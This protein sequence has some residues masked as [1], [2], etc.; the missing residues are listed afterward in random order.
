MACDNVILL[1]RSANQ[2]AMMRVESNHAPGSLQQL[3]LSL[4][5]GLT[6]RLYTFYYRIEAIKSKLELALDEQELAIT[7]HVAITV[8]SPAAVT[9]TPEGSVFEPTLPLPASTSGRFDA[10]TVS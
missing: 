9:A 10:G 4:L 3:R 2:L 7:Q 6:C 5:H 1:C 8:P